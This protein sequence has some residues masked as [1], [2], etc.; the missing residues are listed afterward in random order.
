MSGQVQWG[1]VVMAALV[2]L[3]VM[4]ASAGS[5]WVATVGWVGALAVFAGWCG[6]LVRLRTGEPSPRESVGTTRT[7]RSER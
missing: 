4:S 3:L 2:V 7:K 1:H 5:G 6:L